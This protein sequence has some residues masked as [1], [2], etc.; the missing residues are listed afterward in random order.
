MSNN[1]NDK[2][3][4]FGHFLARFTVA[5]V[6]G[7]AMDLVTA[8]DTDSLADV[9]SLLV[10][11]GISSVPV[12]DTKFE[13]GWKGFIDVLDLV[14]VIATLTN[15]K[16]LA[17]ALSFQEISWE[18]YVEKEADVISKE[19][20]G[21]ICDASQRNRWC[22]VYI[23]APL[24][25]LMDILGKDVNMHRV[26]VIDGDGKV[27]GIVS[28]SKVIAFLARELSKF[29]A[30]SDAKVEQVYNK[31]SVVS[32]GPLDTTIDAF[33]T[34]VSEKVSAVAVVAEKNNGAQPQGTLLGVLSATDLKGSLGPLTEIFGSVQLPVDEYVAKYSDKLG[35]KDAS[36][37]SCKPSD[38]IGAVV[39][40]L[41]TNHIH[42][43]FVVDDDGKPIGVLSLCDLISFFNSV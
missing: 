33:T 18:D 16:Q 15:F 1:A 26:P 29:E 6:L 24:H 11:E 36:V 34:L 7:P 4:A 43:L 25:T 20:I 8:K 35:R 22:P 9:L 17:D 12:H 2:T 21:Q 31:V 30:V 23:E 38:T 37:F 13:G 42:R 5:D 10:K 27:I 14:T 40:I 32:V 3:E 39:H 19:E 28:Q 41:D